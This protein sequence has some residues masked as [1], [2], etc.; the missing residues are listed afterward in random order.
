MDN[1]KDETASFLFYAGNE[2]IHEKFDGYLSFMGDKSY[3]DNLLYYL[4]QN[5][6]N[7]EYLKII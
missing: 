1:L 3:Y 4:T 7:R 6:E 2:A 5:Y